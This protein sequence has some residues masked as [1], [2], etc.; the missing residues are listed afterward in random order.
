M[1]SIY[2]QIDILA[3]GDKVWE[4]VRD[5]PAIHQRLAPG[6]ITA[7]TVETTARL[8]THADG[9]QEREMILGL[10][11]NARRLAYS[12]VDSKA[13]HHN[14]SMQVFDTATPGQCRLVWIIDVL[15]DPL[16]A[17]YHISMEQGAAVIKATLERV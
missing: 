13:A 3:P 11:D 2:K 14:A 9:T 15:P 17:S 4:A 1:A 16:A 7:V 10:D 6:F 5:W 8:V 12:A